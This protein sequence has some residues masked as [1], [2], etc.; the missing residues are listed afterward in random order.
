QVALSLGAWDDDRILEPLANIARSRAF[1][2]WTRAAV[3][4]TVPNR[5]G[6]LLVRL[7]DHPEDATGM[8]P[9]MM[10]DLAAIVGARQDAAEVAACLSA[11]RNPPPRPGR[12]DSVR[13]RAARAP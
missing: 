3:A 9:L 8:L 13:V 5:A 10:F 1:D 7:M 2:Q 12:P 11:L 6:K 4:S